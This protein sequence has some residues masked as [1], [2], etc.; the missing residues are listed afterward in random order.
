M[1]ENENKIKTKKTFA[2]WLTPGAILIELI[3]NST[4]LGIGQWLHSPF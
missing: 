4:P 1:R 3:P 2:K